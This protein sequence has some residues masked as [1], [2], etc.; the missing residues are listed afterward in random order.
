MSQSDNK[1]NVNKKK[2]QTTKPNKFNIFAIGFLDLTFIIE[3]NDKEISQIKDGKTIQ[4]INNENLQLLEFI[5]DNQD[6]INRI[7]LQSEND[8]INEFILLNMASTGN[9]QIEFFPFRSP[10]FQGNGEFFKNIFNTVL[11]KNG[12]L[13]N[14]YS[15]DKKQ[16]YSI[17]IKLIHKNDEHTFEYDEL[18]RESDNPICQEHTQVNNNINEEIEEDNGNDED[19]QWV[20]KGLIP[21]FKRKGCML[22]NLKP[23]CA[24]YDLIYISYIELQNIKGDFEE[25]DF[26]ELMKFF[27]NKKSKIYINYY[28]PEKSD[29]VEP[30]EDDEENSNDDEEEK[31]DNNNNDEDQTKSE[32]EENDN[33]NENKEEDSNDNKSKN[34]TKFAKQKSL[35][36]LYNL[37]D[38]YFFDEKQAYQL[39]NKHLKYNRKKNSK[40][41]L[42]KAN[43]YDYF[44]SSIAGNSSNSGEKIGLFLND[45]DKFTIVFCSNKK[46]SK[47]ILDSKLYPK[48]TTR[49][50]EMINQYKALIQ[51]NKDEYYNIFYSLILGALSSNNKNIGEEIYSA[52]ANALTII[53]KNLECKK[54]NIEFSI[55]KSIDFKT[56]QKGAQENKHKYA[57]KGKEKEFVLDCMNVKQS[58]L[59]EYMP[60]KDKNLKY[61]FKNNKDYLVQKG[62]VDQKGYIMYDKEYRRALGSPIRY[63]NNNNNNRDSNSLT[64]LIN[65]LSMKNNLHS[66]QKNVLTKNIRTEFKLPLQN[67]K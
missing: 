42:N 44:I 37:S 48:P 63:K 41:K 27:K 50:L 66:S 39:F 15:L 56:I 13:V 46:G 52:F 6:L 33:N 22:S 17:K 18:D 25:E 38:I 14:K 64:K 43:I 34:S 9:R 54:N 11:K 4:D 35:N 61:Y 65:D 51:E 57:Q 19:N 1:T 47:E 67:K 58:K 20:K 53:K 12:I 24:K 7:K 2:E 31:E 5:K 36:I 60:L 62:F 32:K 21:K 55:T 45:L 26:I 29:L 59:K 8:S 28:K 3:F 49:N 23:S 30:P 10:K 40:N 16:E